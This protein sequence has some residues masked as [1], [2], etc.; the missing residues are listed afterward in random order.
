[1]TALWTRFHGFLALSPF[2]PASTRDSV[3][4]KGGGQRPALNGWGCGFGS[5]LTA[6]PGKDMA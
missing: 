6:T 2:D 4:A 1:M 3:T 5:A